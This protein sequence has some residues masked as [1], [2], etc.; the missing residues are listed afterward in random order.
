MLACDAGPEPATLLNGDR[1]LLVIAVI[2]NSFRVDSASCVLE[3][4]GSD[5]FGHIIC[6]EAAI[7]NIPALVTS[8]ASQSHP[9]LAS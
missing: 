7:R 5:V 9:K 4:P 6:R 8:T 1:S 3:N 2:L